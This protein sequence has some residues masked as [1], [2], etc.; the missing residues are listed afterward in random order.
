MIADAGNFEQRL[1]D[2][3]GF[4]AALNT[5]KS[6]AGVSQDKLLQ[7]LN[8][9]LNKAASNVL[10]VLNQR[11]DKLSEVWPLG[12]APIMTVEGILDDLSELDPYFDDSITTPRRKLKPLRQSKVRTL[13]ESRS[14]L[15][16]LCPDLKDTA[17]IDLLDAQKIALNLALDNAL[18]LHAAT[19]PTV[20]NIGSDIEKTYQT[21][22]KQLDGII[23]A[24]EGFIELTDFIRESVAA[25]SH[26]IIDSLEKIRDSFSN[27]ASDVCN[28]RA[29]N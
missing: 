11:Q 20:P 13:F 26:E 4:V 27:C 21:Y 16:K 12:E 15:Y 5:L 1:D 8:A 14:A 17:C 24:A 19:S 25:Q 18:R 29:T 2:Y 23:V 28:A 10:A 6:N 9:N 22:K 3:M 7:D